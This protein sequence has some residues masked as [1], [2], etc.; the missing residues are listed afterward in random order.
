M[1][2]IK[3]SKTSDSKNLKGTTTTVVHEKFRIIKE[4]KTL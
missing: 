4:N 2:T 3:E 1:D